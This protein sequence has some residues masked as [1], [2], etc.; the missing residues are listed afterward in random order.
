MRAVGRQRGEVAPGERLHALHE[1]LLG[2]G[3]DEQHAQPADRLLAQQPRDAE[4]R[5]DAAEVV[6]GARDD[7]AR[8]DLRERR[9]GAERDAPRRRG[10]ASREPVSPPSAT[11]SRPAEDGEHHRRR[12]VRALE[13]PGEALAEELAGPA[14]RTAGSSARRRGGRRSTTVRS[15]SR[16]PASATT[17]QVGRLGQR[18]RAGTT[19]ARRRCRRRSPAASDRADERARARRL[20]LSAASPAPQ[21]QQPERPPVRPVGALLLDARRRSP[22]RAAARRSTRRPRRSPSEADGRSNDAR[23][24]TASCASRAAGRRSTRSAGPGRLGRHG[25]QRIAAGR[26]RGHVTRDPDCLFCRILAGE[27]PAQIVDED[28]RTVSLHGHQPGDPRPRA[29]HPARRTPRTSTRPTRR[30]SPRPRSPRSASRCAP[31]TGSAPT[32]STC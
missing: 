31:A 28:E 17:F 21:R 23:W 10:A 9:R 13:Q 1:R 24:S 12:R 8:A 30:T 6:V 16:S 26:L 3:R 19:A 29:R 7:R 4:Q 2:A 25:R 15:A 14:G 18:A 22:R 27:L 20:R 11:S 32:A 5:R